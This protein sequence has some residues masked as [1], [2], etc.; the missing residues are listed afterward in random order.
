MK[1][2]KGRI[3]LALFERIIDEA[4]GWVFHLQIANFGEPLLHP[5]LGLMIRHAI[6][7]GFFVELFTN[8]ALMDK[9]KARMFIEAGVGKINVS[10]DALDSELYKQ[11]RGI[12]LQPVLDNLRALFDLR[13]ELKSRTPFIVLAMADLDSNPG[14]KQI[15]QKEFSRLGTDSWY[16]TP[17][18]NWAGSAELSDGVKPKGQSY[19]GCLFPWYLMNVALDGTVTP[20]CIDA[21]LR[22]A[23]GNANLKPLRKIW[24]DAPARKLRRALIDRDLDALAQVSNCHQCSRLYYSQNAYTANRARIEVAQFL[25]LAGL[26]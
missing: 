4:A 9:T 6:S 23:I 24:N 14:Q 21:E 18:M 10:I 22:N 2:K 26:R 13:A 16:A 1:R 11:I 3:E 19:K 17:S 5:E 15:V 12:E 25:K 7:K 20:C 8:A